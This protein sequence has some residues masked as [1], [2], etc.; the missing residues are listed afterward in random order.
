MTW[1]MVSWD[2][3]NYSMFLIEFLETS[4]IILMKHNDDL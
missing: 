4:P 2:K 3:H 1:R